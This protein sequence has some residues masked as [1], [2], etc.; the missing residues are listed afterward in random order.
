MTDIA[1]MNPK[2][3]TRRTIV[4]FRG[5]DLRLA[6]NPALDHAL[7]Q[8]DV[9][10]IYIHAIDKNDWAPGAASR[11]WLHHSL[12]ALD[13]SL[14]E[15]GSQLI[16]RQGITIAELASIIAE[17]KADQLVWLRSYTPHDRML[18]SQV[19]QHLTIPI[20]RFAASL[21]FQRNEVLNQQG[22]PYRVFTPYW[23]ACQAQGLE[24][25]LTP[26]PSS[27]PPVPKQ[28]NSLT[29]DALHLRP[30]PAWDHAFYSTKQ[31][32]ETGAAHRL[33]NF[34]EQQL[35][36]YA[37][38]RDFM[39]HS[40]SSGLS[41]HLRFGEIS[42]QRVVAAIQETVS[43]EKQ[44]GLMSAAEKLL[45]ELGWREFAH[46]ILYHHPETCK[47]PLNPKYKKFPWRHSAK[48]LR[49]WQQGKTGIPLV[50]AGMRELWH[51]GTMHNRVRMVVASFLTKNC[52]IHWLEGARWFWDTLLDADLAANSL[53]WQWVAGCGADA[54]PYYRIFNPVTQSEKFD[55]DGVYIRRWVPELAT[56]PNQ[57]IHH[58]WK[59]KN[60]NI[61]QTYSA[62]IVDLKLSREAALER[63]K[64]IK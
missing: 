39:A 21:L 27:L 42:P 10:P 41:P 26:A 22:L 20:H 1:D 25:T 33:D 23:R 11:S 44:P 51:S 59:S 14:R 46:M 38:K 63:Y 53:N 15:R 43:H 50:D 40:V 12:C 56:L 61:R 32:G 64:G 7:S 62:P 18:D 5:Y 60:K 29:I 28:V 30:I 49:H 9:I 24:R 19:K 45:S 52:G 37:N 58:P 48:R 17:T 35:I 8:G 36:D 31:P 34:I 3:T 55:P 47:Q 16:I 4:W 13:H 54:A 6:D 57:H 2:T